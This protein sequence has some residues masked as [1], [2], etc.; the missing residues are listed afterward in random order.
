MLDS[1]GPEGIDRLSGSVYNRL[2]LQ[3]EPGVEHHFT[4]RQ[5]SDGAQKCVELR[6]F[7]GINRLDTG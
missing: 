2:A 6:I 3:F 5:S 7:S 4:S 1:G